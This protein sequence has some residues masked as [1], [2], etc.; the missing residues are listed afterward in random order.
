[1]PAA[2]ACYDSARVVLEAQR[3]ARPA[4]T[5]SEQPVQMPLAL[6]YAGLG[7]KA[8]AIRLGREGAQLVPVSR[9]ALAG[10]TVLL[11]LVEIYVRTGEYDAALDHVEYLLSIPSSVSIPL[12]RIDPLYAPLRGN[13]RFERLVQWKR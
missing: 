5:A 11:D 2:H 3:I 1:M 4:H 7:R 8:E 10:P 6:A 12:L 9:D 13:P